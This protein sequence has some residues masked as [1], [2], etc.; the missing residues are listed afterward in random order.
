VDGI[1]R[2]QFLRAA[3]AAVAVGAVTVALPWT[4]LPFRYVGEVPRDGTPFEIRGGDADAVFP[5]SV[6]SGDPTPTGA[7]LWT[8]VAP[9][10]VRDGADIGLE[11]AADERFAD[12]VYRTV[13]PSSVLVAET[14]HTA[15]FDASGLLASDR[16]YYFRFIYHGTATRTGRLRTLPE[17]GAHVANLRLAVITCNVFQNGYFAAMGH[18]ARED[19]DFVVHLGDIIYEYNGQASYNGKAYRGRGLDLPSG[20]PRMDTRDDLEYVW[21]RYRGDEHMVSM[22]ER[23]TLIVT[24]D[25]HEVANDRFFDYDEGRHY[26]D[27]AFRLRDDAA[28]SDAYFRAAASAFFHWLPVRIGIDPDAADPLDAITLYRRFRFGRLADLWMLDE[29]WYRS[30]PPSE[31]GV[32]EPDAEKVTVTQDARVDPDATMLGARQKQWLF[33]GLRA[34]DRTWKVL[35]QQ[36]QMSPLGLILPPAWVLV[37]L[38]AWD[39]Y[40]A[41]RQQLAAVLADV[42]NAIVMTGDL[43][44]GMV[45]YVEQDYSAAAESA[46]NRV[47]VEFMAPGVTSANLHEVIEENLPAPIDPFPG[48]DEVMEDVVL[49][50]NPH[51][52]FFNSTRYG[53]A[54]VEFTPSSATYS[55]FMVDKATSGVANNH[56]LIATYTVPAGIVRAIETFRA[57]PSGV[58]ALEANDVVRSADPRRHGVLSDP[59]AMWVVRSVEGLRRVLREEPWRAQ[60]LHEWMIALR[61]RRFADAASVVARASLHGGLAPP[62]GPASTGTAAAAAVSA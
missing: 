5:Q 59:G 39:G 37:N 55:H 2:R 30:R 22:L 45:G 4:R 44:T 14:Y 48:W 16:H 43:H 42:E 7:I 6:A 20:H 50:G 53:Y 8:R 32:T 15:R 19:V 57:S 34:S 51:L 11:I 28:A 13:I 18:V 12:V 47:A 27:P 49:T 54:I 17:E 25:D 56:K 36:V 1:S 41:E 33:D 52:V 9:E 58:A 40:E 35:G 10:R 26:G 31:S 38:D 3:G 21:A 60:A 29:R 61:E 24:W 46:G 62:R 23:H